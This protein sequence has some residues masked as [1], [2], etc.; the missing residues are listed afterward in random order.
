MREGGQARGQSCVE[1][2]AAGAEA[3]DG[4]VERA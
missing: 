2:A 4:K 1:K 3:R